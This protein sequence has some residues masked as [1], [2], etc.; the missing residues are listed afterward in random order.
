MHPIARTAN[1]DQSVTLFYGWHLRFSESCPGWS[2][3]PIV[4]SVPAII[5]KLSIAILR[6]EDNQLSSLEAH[7]RPVETRLF[8]LVLEWGVRIARDDVGRARRWIRQGCLPLWRARVLTHGGRRKADH[9]GSQRD[10]VVIR[11]F[12]RSYQ[13]LG[14]PSCVRLFPNQIYAR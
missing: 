13:T 4:I 11:D 8:N 12:P 2:A 9:H 1:S 5:H 7:S 3:A 14:M 6:R 10:R